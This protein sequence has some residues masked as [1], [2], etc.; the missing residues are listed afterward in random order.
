MKKQ[1]PAP[2]EPVS[3]EK[4]NIIYLEGEEKQLLLAIKQAPLAVVIF[5]HV[6]CSADRSLAQKIPEIA[7][8][9]P[10]VKFVFIDFDKNPGLV[11]HF[12]ITK[13]PHIKY[14]RADGNSVAEAAE[15]IGG[16][17][18]LIMEKLKEMLPKDEVRSEQMESQES[19]DY[20]SSQY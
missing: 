8:K 9:Y 12:E 1:Q 19:Q 17:A 13:V 18:R 5:T 7:A 14:C 4:S 20:S 15:T 10:E 11:A 2:P 3:A 16:S 6:W